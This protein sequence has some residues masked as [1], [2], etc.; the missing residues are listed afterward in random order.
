VTNTVAV[1]R[2]GTP[3]QL[4]SGWVHTNGQTLFRLTGPASQ[5][6]TIQASSNLVNWIGLYTNTTTS[7][8]IDFRDPQTPINPRRFYRVVPSP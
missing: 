8:V 3:I 7:A 4:G 2:I 6:F 5:G 1:V